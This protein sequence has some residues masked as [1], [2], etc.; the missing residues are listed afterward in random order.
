MWK[1]IAAILAGCRRVGAE[2]Y[3]YSGHRGAA[4]VSHHPFDVRTL[5]GVRPVQT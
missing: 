3:G 1:P 2:R 4:I 5:A